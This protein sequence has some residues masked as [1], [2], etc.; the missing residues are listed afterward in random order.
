MFQVRRLVVYM[1]MVSIGLPVVT[2]SV[3]TLR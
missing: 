1:D 2:V 3:V